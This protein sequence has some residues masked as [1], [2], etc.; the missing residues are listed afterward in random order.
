MPE[1][2]DELLRKVQNLS[3]GILASPLE[4]ELAR[5]LKAYDEL[6]TAEIENL[7]DAGINRLQALREGK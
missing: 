1:T 2:T 3:L 7:S 6:F 4:C 5:R